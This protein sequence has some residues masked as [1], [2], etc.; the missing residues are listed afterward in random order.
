L[1]KGILIRKEENKME[2]NKKRIAFVLSGALIAV[3]IGFFGWKN[4]A[5]ATSDSAVISEILM[6][7]PDGKEFI[8]LYN[9]T[10]DD[11]DLSGW[12]LA[13]Y[14]KDR[15]WDNPY[16]KKVFP[17]N[18][19]LP[20]DSFFLISV[21]TS[22]FADESDWNLGYTSY[23][24]GNTDG[25]VAIFPEDN[26][27]FENAVDAV[28]WG[29]AKVN[30]FSGLAAPTGKSLEKIDPS[31]ENVFGNWQE[32]CTDG[33]TPAGAPQFCEDESE[34]D[35]TSPDS[36]DP[37]ENNLYSGNIYLNEI[38]GYPKNGSDDEYIEIRNNGNT[39]IDLYGWIL[40]DGSKSGKYTFENHETIDPEGY[41][42]IYHPESKLALNNS[43]ESVYLFDPDGNLA[44]SVTYG[45]SPKD[46]SY[47]FDGKNW[48]WS[49][50][51]T[52]GEENKFDSE[53][54]VKIEK[55]KHAYKNLYTEFS[56]KAKDKETKD[57]KFVWDFGDD[58]RSYLE[59][60]SHKY[61]D[62]GKYKVTLTVTD[63]SQAVEK[64]FTLNVK[65]YPVPDLTIV[66]FVP[67][68]EGND[69]ESETIDLKNNSKTKIS[70][71]GW[72]IATGSA[73]KLTNH[74]IV[75]GIMLSSGQTLT[76]TREMSR[77]TLNNKSGKV[78]LLSPDGNVAD[79]ISYEKKKI[80]EGEAYAKING[81]WQWLAP[82]ENNPEEIAE[83]ELSGI[84]ENG[85]I[86]GAMDIY[87]PHYP[88][89]FSSED[90]YIFLSQINFFN[91]SGDL[92]YTPLYDPSS[93]Y[94]YL[95]ASLI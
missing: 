19:V 34:D 18:S 33:G 67:N 89:R 31:G 52:P 77:F 36:N 13:Y 62:T 25:A 87:S 94:A 53:P 86:L 73:E 78:E 93:T 58:H 29:S 50:Y 20:S 30:Y 37:S 49:S 55:P 2:G 38:L 95:I 88:S 85:E 84:S 82:G 1:L 11:I 45:K 60:P 21:K 51:L 4:S 5:V 16:R 26:F 14:S 68:P 79:E 63:E 59:K 56:V 72:K 80:A 61:L 3:A 44:S 74:P 32:S 39:S 66:K 70:L 8:E 83:G 41:F 6:N 35:S 23:Q 57:L 43:N 65:K 81:A 42:V 91:Q 46:A 24:M 92:N 69:S 7:G 27:S 17:D 76:I 90:A 9:P 47:N 71:D 28:G 64:S 48:R 22:D 75:D 10:S 12:T 15:D 40:R 54:S